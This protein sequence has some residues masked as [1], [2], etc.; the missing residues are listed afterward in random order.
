[1][2]QV[3]EH[4]EGCILLIRAQPGARRVGIQGEVGGALKVAV[5]AS[6]DK[7]K[8]NQAIMEVLQKILGLKNSQIQLIGGFTNRQKKVLI[9]D[10]S[11]TQLESKIAEMLEPQ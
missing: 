4:P 1:M 11:K 9:R 10:L 3:S 7:G 2:I 5:S 8:A 6:P